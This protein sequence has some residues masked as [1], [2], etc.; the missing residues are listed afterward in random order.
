M[1]HRRSGNFEFVNFFAAPGSNGTVGATDWILPI[2]YYD[3][4]YIV[5]T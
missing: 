2:V 1:L 5:L 4:R 3:Y